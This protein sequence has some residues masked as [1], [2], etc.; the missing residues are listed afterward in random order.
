M[1]ARFTGNKVKSLANRKDN[2]E[3]KRH[4]LL[5]A[6]GAGNAFQM[7]GNIRLRPLV[8]LHIGVDREGVAAFHAAGFPFA[9]GLHAAPVN[10]K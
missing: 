4:A 10:R 7:V 2:P 9:I 5:L 6:L 1:S 8:K 3:I